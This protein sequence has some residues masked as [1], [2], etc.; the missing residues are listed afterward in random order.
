MRRLLVAGLAIAFLTGIAY[1]QVERADTS[2]ILVQVSGSVPKTCRDQVGVV[3]KIGDTTRAGQ[4]QFQC[5]LTWG[6]GLKANLGANWILVTPAAA[7]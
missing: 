1:A 2:D 5:V 3:R 7:R 4:R 6:D